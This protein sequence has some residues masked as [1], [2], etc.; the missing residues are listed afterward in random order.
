[1]QTN[2]SA[3][4]QSRVQSEMNEKFH[5]NT[6]KLLAG[7]K[8]LNDVLTG[9]V[10]AVEQFHPEMLCSILLL[11]SENSIFRQVV[12]PSLPDFFNTEVNGL[13]IGLGIGSCGTS[14]F[15][16]QRVIVEDIQNHPY[17]ATFK[18]LAAKAGIAACWSQPILSAEAKVL[19]TFAIYHRQ[20]HTPTEMDVNFIEELSRQASIAIE[21]SIAVKKL[22]ESEAHYRLLT[23]DVYDVVWKADCDLRFIYISPADERMRGFTS[24][25]MLGHHPFEHMTEEGI[26]TAKEIMLDAQLSRSQGINPKNVSIVTQ[27]FCKNGSL[28]WV[29][30]NPISELDEQGTVIGYHGFT[31]D[32]SERVHIENQ[33]RIKE[34]YQRALLDN[35][36]FAVWLKDTES[37]FLLVNEGFERT[38]DFGSADQIAGKNDFDISPAELAEGYRVDDLKVMKTRQKM[39]MEELIQ[40]DGVLKWFET[41]KAPVIDD[42]GELLGTVGFARDISER[43]ML[44]RSV[45]SMSEEFQ[46]SIGRELHDNLGQLISA[47]A[48]Q[49]RAIQNKLSGTSF[50]SEFASDI[51]FISSQAEKAIAHCKI[52]A[53]GLVPFELESS[54]L[55]LALAEYAAEISFSHGISCEFFGDPELIIDDANLEL[56]LFRIVQEAVNNAV[57]HSGGK[58]VTITIFQESSVLYLTVSDDGS[59]NAEACGKGESTSGLGLKIMQYRANQV[60]VILQFN[61]PKKGG[62]EISLIKRIEQ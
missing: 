57:R 11:D 59:G 54:G 6:F 1:M 5:R 45:V 16:G 22:Q 32:I 48:Y 50:E 39:N 37:R 10:H 9:I 40:T 41:Y 31:R 42:Q 14:A 56:Q 61:Y 60:G 26:A 34:R 18:A 38:Y 20:P 21:R 36:P 2:L 19:G 27:L 49:S 58:R 15:L 4:E 53:H 55:A 23:E 46:R 28:K 35:F 44:E 47:I 8:P 7:N 43:K 12:A 62:T 30:I 25:E 17:W 24:E 33:L 13:K 29:E 51:A 3:L 52:L